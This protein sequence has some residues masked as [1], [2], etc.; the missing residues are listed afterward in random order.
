MSVPPS[1]FLEKHLSTQLHTCITED[2]RLISISIKCKGVCTCN[3]FNKLQ[4][5]Q[6]IHQVN[7]NLVIPQR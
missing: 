4:I 1:N 3:I 6:A 2:T 5:K 7:L